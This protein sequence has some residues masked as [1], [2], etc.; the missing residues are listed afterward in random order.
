MVPHSELSAGLSR[1][2]RERLHCREEILAAASELFAQLGYEK[3]AVKQIAGRV[4]VSVGALY[5]HFSGKEEILRELLENSMRELRRRSDAACSADDPPLEQLR[6]RLVSATEHFKEHLDFL[7]IYHN[8]NPLILEGIIREEI[9][10]NMETMSKLIL[11]AM[12]RGDIP[13]DD[14]SVLA[15]VFIGSVQELMHMF[16]ERG[17]RDAFDDVPGIIDHLIL[18]PLEL[19][20][21]RASK[22]EGSSCR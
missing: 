20:A 18:N 9:E 11:A 3:T 6:S 19:R 2:E 12:D 10:R 8:E 21:K 22:R 17:R 13:R 4:G 1:R 5:S 14:P 15:A 16:A 7:M